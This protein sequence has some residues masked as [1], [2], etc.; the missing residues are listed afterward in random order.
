MTLFQIFKDKAKHCSVLLQTNFAIKCCLIPFKKYSESS[1][2]KNKSP[3]HR[4]KREQE[5]L[6]GVKRQL[7]FCFHHFDKKS[8][9]V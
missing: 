7:P 9:H 3:C 8:A 1:I 5:S 2:D 4:A 6:P